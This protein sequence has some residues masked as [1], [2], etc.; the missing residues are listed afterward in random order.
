MDHGAEVFRVTWIPDAPGGPAVL[1]C[2]DDGTAHLWSTTTQE[3][4]FEVKHDKLLNAFWV[5]SAPEGPAILTASGNDVYRVWDA[6]TGSPRFEMG[7]DHVDQFSDCSWIPDEARCPDVLI[8]STAGV[9]GLWNSSTGEERIR[10][11]HPGLSGA[12]WITDTTGR[13]AFMSWS[14][15]NTICHWDASTGERRGCISTPFNVWKASWTIL[16]DG[17]QAILGWAYEG[18]FLCDAVT[19]QQIVRKSPR[20]L[21][22]DVKWIDEASGGPAILSTCQDNT[23]RLWDVTTR[24]QYVHI[25]TKHPPQAAWIPGTA[26]GSVILSWSRR[27][28]VIQ[29]WD[30]SATTN[31][32]LAEMRHEGE[33]RGAIWVSDPVHPAILSWANDCT[34]ALWDVS[35]CRLI[36]QFELDDVPLTLSVNSQRLSGLQ[37]AVACGEAVGVLEFAGGAQQTEAG[38]REQRSGGRPPNL[39]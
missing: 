16:A 26:V 3:K 25:E 38:K 28:S 21:I 6:Q 18:I 4:R 8:W 7:Y 17:R 22:E 27:G 14:D 36:S 39:L 15:N 30:A 32:L 29:V 24:K 13:P 10:V 35:T 2:S 33:V 23:I 11:E 34:V 1:S 12:C 5:G 19:G 31:R 37:F 9:V 20:T